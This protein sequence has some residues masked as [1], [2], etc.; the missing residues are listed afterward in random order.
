MGLFI[1]KPKARQQG[2][3]AMLWRYR[4]ER[5]QQRLQPGAPIGMD[6][7]FQMV[8]FYEK[9]GF[10]T[11]YKDL[12]FQGVAQGSLDPNVRTL[13]AADFDTIERFDRHHFPVARTEFLQRW[14]F[15]HGAHLLGI[16]E[17]DKL[18]GYGVARQAP[19]GYKIGPLFAD[20]PDIAERLL[21]SLMSRFVGEQVQIDVPEPNVFGIRLAAQ[22]GLAE[23][24]GCARMYRGPMPQLPLLHI[25]G[26]TSLEFG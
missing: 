7:V 19:Q 25:F 24:F 4:L 21:T 6:G 5:L 14:I 16:V 12:R 2:L 1:L 3:G 15:R 17:N 13:Q 22:S 9:G 10:S 11:A 23:V 26:V 8:P 18:V 20:R